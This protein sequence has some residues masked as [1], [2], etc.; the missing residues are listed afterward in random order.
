MPFLAL[1]LANIAVSNEY[2]GDIL[3]LSPGRARA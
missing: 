1:L 3:P 2:R